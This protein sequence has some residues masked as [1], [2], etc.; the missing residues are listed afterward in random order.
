MLVFMRTLS[1]STTTVALS[2]TTPATC[3]DLPNN[4]TGKGFLT[5]LAALCDGIRTRQHNSEKFLVFPI[6]V[7]QKSPT[8]SKTPDVKKRIAHRLS[9]WKANSYQLLFQETLKDMQ[10]LQRARR[11]NTT[12][13]QRLKTYNR[14]L[15][16]GEIRRAVRYISDRDQ[17]IILDPASVSASGDNVIDVLQSLHPEQSQTTFADLPEYPSLPELVP[18]Q[19]TDEDICSTARHL[20]GAAGL[21]GTDAPTLKRWLLQ[22]RQPSQQL[23]HALCHLTEWIANQLVPWGAIRALFSNRLL[24]FAKPNG[25]VRPIAVGQI[26]RRLLAKTVV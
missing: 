9:L 7:L 23:R 12:Q 24:A 21:G 18:L 5:E 22:F 26:W 1:G 20:H 17:S 25:G 4:S 8:I 14:L 6:L 15:L 19:V 11:A 16:Q 13:E 3:Y 2:P 10:N